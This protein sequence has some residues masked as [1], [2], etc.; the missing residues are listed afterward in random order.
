M[1][2]KNGLF[3]VIRL[4]ISEWIINIA[5]K[6]MPKGF[7]KDT[8]NDLQVKYLMECIADYKPPKTQ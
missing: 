7:E 4:C 3:Y 2:S 8:A 1:K 5:I 6:I